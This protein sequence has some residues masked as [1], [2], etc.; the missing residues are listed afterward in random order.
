MRLYCL[1]LDFIW[2]SLIDSFLI[3]NLNCRFR[4]FYFKYEVFGFEMYLKVYGNFKEF[5]FFDMCN[6]VLNKYFRFIVWLDLLD[7]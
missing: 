6:L 1:N 3:F 5:K 7:L 2:Y 4:Y